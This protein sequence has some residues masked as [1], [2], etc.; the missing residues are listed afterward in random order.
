METI[1][2]GA[3]EYHLF[4]TRDPSSSN[5]PA[6][7]AGTPVISVYEENNT[8]QI[9]AGVSLSVD[10]DSV[11][12]LNQIT[13]VGTSR[14]GYEAGKKYQAVIT[15]GT[16]NSIS[17]V[18]EV[19]WEFRVES[20]A[21]GAVRSLK[22]ALFITDTVSTTTSN[23]TTAVNLTDF[24]DAQAPNNSTTGELWLWQDSTGELEY[25]R[26]QSMTSL[27]AAVEAWPAGGALSAAVASGDK[28]WRVGY[29]DVNT[30]AI[31]DAQVV[32]DGN[33]TPWDG[34]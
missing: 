25:F 20:A 16:V 12:G 10:Y 5:A 24:L 14:N 27:V 3:T 31:N 11:T 7:L 22:E 28:L 2:L 6:T 9:T 23:T 34:A 21:D 18:G 4:T 30:A 17:A 13:V 29:V 15:T 26:V 1:A 32:G 8:T 19:V 33:G